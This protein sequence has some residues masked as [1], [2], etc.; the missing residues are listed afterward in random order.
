MTLRAP[1][2]SCQALELETVFRALVAR[3]GNIGAAARALGVPA[4]DLRAL[5]RA[6]P[7]LIEA[8]LEVEEQA[9]DEAEA[10]LRAAL[11]SPLVSERLA[12]A[13]HIVRSSPAARRR[14]FGRQPEGPKPFAAPTTLKWRDP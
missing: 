11:K 13:G 7:R 14:G 12:A 6:E 9:L 8:A 4:A 5:A 2:A 3:N 10:T 1:P